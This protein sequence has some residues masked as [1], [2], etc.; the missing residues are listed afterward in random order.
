MKAKQML[1]HL[2]T[3]E[4]QLQKKIELCEQASDKAEAYSYLK[5]DTILDWRIYVK[6]EN[7]A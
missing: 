4:S 3:I 7:E 1:E 2:R 5:I 6:E